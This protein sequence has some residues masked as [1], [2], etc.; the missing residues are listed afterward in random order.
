M[1][2]CQVQL[3]AALASFTRLATFMETTIYAWGVV[4]S[5]HFIP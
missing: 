4:E 2:P 1:I 3:E 5:I